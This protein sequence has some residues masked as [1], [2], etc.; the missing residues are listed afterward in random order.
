MQKHLKQNVNLT[1]STLISL[2]T[3]SPPQDTKLVAMACSGHSSK[4]SGTSCLACNENQFVKFSIKE[5][6]NVSDF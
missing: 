2:E 3:N 4:K 5:Q 6:Y 1:A